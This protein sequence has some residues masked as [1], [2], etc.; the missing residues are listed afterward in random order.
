VVSVDELPAHFNPDARR[1]H[2]RW[3]MGAVV[4]ERRTGQ[5]KAGP[6]SGHAA[7][8]VLNGAIHLFRTPVLFDPVEPSL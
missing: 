5:A 7:G 1:Q 6:A 3:R 4:R 8:V 2:R